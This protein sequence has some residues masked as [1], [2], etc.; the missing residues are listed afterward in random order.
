FK[1]IEFTR[2][3]QW[4]NNNQFMLRD[5]NETRKKLGL[6][7][8]KIYLLSVSRDVPRKNI[9]ILPK[10]MNKLDERFVLIR[11]GETNRILNQFNDKKQVIPLIDVDDSIYPLY[12]NASNILIH[13][14]IDGGFEATFI[15]AMFS[16]LPVMTF[17]MPISREVLKDKAIYPF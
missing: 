11:I 15:E 1:N 13:T 12:F 6:D 16:D 7:N 10:I 14:A 8:D 9:D 4:L 5:K 2:I 3:H 17:N